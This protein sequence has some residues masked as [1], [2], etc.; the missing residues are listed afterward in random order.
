MV[1]RRG[2]SNKGNIVDSQKHEVR[3][4]NLVQ[5]AGVV[6]FVTIATARN[7]E[8]IAVDTDVKTG[9]VLKAIIFEENWNFEGNVTGVIDWAI[10]KSKAGQDI[11][12]T[13]WNPA[14]PNKPTRSQTFMSGME[15]PA[16]I[17]N[18]A[19]VK[20]VGTILIPK[21]KQRMSEGDAWTLTY[22]ASQIVDACGKFIFKEYR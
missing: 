18:S 6:R 22:F 19:S 1:F 21:G 3:Y 5:A 8:D 7:I 2:R 9:S 20:R 13:N 10:F 14:V 17:N 16:G 11:D 15:M 12:S 4:S